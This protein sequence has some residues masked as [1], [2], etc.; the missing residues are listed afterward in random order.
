VKTALRCAPALRGPAP[1]AR[2]R[3]QAMVGA[4]G[5]QNPFNFRHLPAGWQTASHSG[6]LTASA[7]VPILK[8]DV[9][10]DRVRPYAT[11]RTRPPDRAGLVLA[12]ANKVVALVFAKGVVKAIPT[13]ASSAL[14]TRLIVNLRVRR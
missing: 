2:S 7:P 14:A 10:R 3:V 12:G 8:G 6:G 13:S 9:R 1:P 5:E 4:P 11:C